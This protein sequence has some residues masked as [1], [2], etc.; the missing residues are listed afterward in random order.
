M[1]D[2][3]AEAVRGDHQAVQGHQLRHDRTLEAGAVDHHTIAIFIHGAFLA[4]YVHKY[5]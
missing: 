1:E 3:P 5:T 4:T 2:A